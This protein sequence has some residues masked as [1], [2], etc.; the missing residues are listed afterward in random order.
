MRDADDLRDARETPSRAPTAIAV[1]PPI[2]ASISS[3][4]NV[5]ARRARRPAR[6]P[7]R[8]ARAKVRR[9]TRSARAGAPARRGFAERGTRRGRRRA[10]RSR[11]AVRAPLEAR[12]PASPTPRVRAATPLLACRGSPGAA[13]RAQQRRHRRDRRVGA[14]SS[15]SSA[16]SRS[17]RPASSSSVAREAL[18]RGENRVDRRAVFL[19]QRLDGVE[20]RRHRVEFGRIGSR[21]RRAPARRSAASALASACSAAA[22]LRRARRT[23]HRSATLAERVRG[24]P[25]R[26][27]RAAFV[28]ERGARARQRTAMRSALPRTSRR[29]RKRSSSPGSSAAASISPQRKR[30]NVE[31][32][33]ARVRRLRAARRA[34]ALRR[35]ALVVVRAQALPRRE[36]GIACKAVEH[37]AREGGLE[38]PV[39]FALPDRIDDMGPDRAQLTGADGAPVHA[40]FER[41]PR[42]ISRDD[43]DVVVGGEHDPVAPRAGSRTRR[44]VRFRA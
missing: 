29:S 17:S 39:R 43:H 41:P 2:P 16:A 32:P 11:R 10:P 30:A 38:Q 26:V 22:P 23:P 42:V 31:R 36:R 25:E 28:F 4:T 3:K 13:R 21:R 9:R 34:R 20:T 6:P 40:R 12:R 44:R 8:A 24:V 27:D 19:L 37:V 33:C 18:A 5:R 15:R 1:A 14:R 7:A 35:A